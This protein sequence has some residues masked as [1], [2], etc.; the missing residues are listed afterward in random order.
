MNRV[1]LGLRLQDWHDS[2]NDPVYAVGSFYFADKKHPSEN[3]VRK[4][5][6]NLTLDYD[7]RKLMLTGEKV[8]TYNKFYDKKIDDLRKFAGWTDEELKADIKDLEEIINSLQ[9][10]LKEDYVK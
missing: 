5:L 3:V 10:F 9:K 6:R 7:R 2:M 8:S 1:D 4:A